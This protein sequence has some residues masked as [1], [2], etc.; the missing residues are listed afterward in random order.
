VEASD[1]RDGVLEDSQ[2]F[3]EDL[4]ATVNRAIGD[5]P[6]AQQIAVELLEQLCDVPL[7]ADLAQQKIREIQEHRRRL[8]QKLDREVDFR[9]AALDYF[10]VHDQRLQ[11]PRVIELD[12][13]REYA[14]RSTIDPLT[15]VYNRRFL[16]EILHR[17][18]S[19]ARRYGHS[20]SILFLDID[21]FKLVNDKHG[22]QLGDEVLM[23]FASTLQ[24]HLRE[25]DV[26]ARY[27][28]EEFVAVLP[29]TTSEGALHVA[30]RILSACRNEAYPGG[31]SITASVGI[32]EYP[33]DGTSAAAVIE[34]ADKHLYAA[35]L[36]GKDQAIARAEDQ[37]RSPR[38]RASCLVTATIT[39][40]VIQGAMHN[41][42]LYGA[43]LA[44]D[45][46]LPIGRHVT[47][48]IREVQSDNTITV[49]AQVVWT[50]VFGGLAHTAGIRYHTPQP[51]LIELVRNGPGLKHAPR[52]PP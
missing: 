39:E 16:H 30:E 36:A 22:H 43:M 26:A 25:E 1:H 17:E 10:M 23:S 33:I 32:A 28:G 3:T 12:R 51:E 19:R 15:G 45:R 38:Y 13:F 42:S 7:P 14:L 52:T 8:G 44:L 49:S 35:K 2:A 47:L 20:Y 4:G 34:Q 50:S 5:D 27:G 18:T 11:N 29:A 21:D 31:V 41:V 9:V 37:R 48:E 6:A 24:M 40:D 46:P